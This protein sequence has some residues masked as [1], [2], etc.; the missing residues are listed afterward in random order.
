MLRRVELVLR[1]R[2]RSELGKL[3]NPTAGVI[4]VQPKVCQRLGCAK[5][6]NVTPHELNFKIV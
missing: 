4:L 5:P 1:L 2:S 6:V 3:T